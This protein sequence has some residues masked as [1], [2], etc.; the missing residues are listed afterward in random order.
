MAIWPRK[1]A[2]GYPGTSATESRLNL[3]CSSRRRGVPLRTRATPGPPLSLSLSS[4]FSSLALFLSPC[5]VFLSSLFLGTARKLTR[6]KCPPPPPGGGPSREHACTVSILRLCKFHGRIPTG[7]RDRARLHPQAE[8]PPRALRDS[9][10][11]R[12]RRRGVKRI[13]RIRATS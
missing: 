13:A 7:P 11:R 2:P 4:F 3:E 6:I 12:P 10:A 5:A 9:R 1:Q 8:S